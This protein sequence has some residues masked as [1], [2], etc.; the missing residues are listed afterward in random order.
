MKEFQLIQAAIMGVTLGVAQVSAFATTDAATAK[1]E[2]SAAAPAA[3]S[4]STSVECF[5]A[6]SCKG[7]NDCGVEQ[8]H[9]DAANKAYKNKFKKAATMS[10]SGST[11]CAAKK[12]HLSWAKKPSEKDCFTAG[13]FIFTK[14]ADNKPVI[15]D[16][17]GTRT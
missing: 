16:K 5:G 7:K 12:G 1:P 9:I 15:K 11:A 2:A 4:A 17:K 3:A 13:G 6:N 10:C 14:G 8:S